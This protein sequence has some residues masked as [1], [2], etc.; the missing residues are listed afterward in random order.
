MPTRALFR[1]S[2]RQLARGF[3]LSSSWEMQKA[4]IHTPAADATLQKHH[5]LT[6]CVDTNPASLSIRHAHS[7]GD[8]QR[9]KTS[10]QESEKQHPPPL[11][12]P[13]PP[14]AHIPKP[15]PRKVWVRLHAA[16]V[17]APY[18]CQTHHACVCQACIRVY[19]LYGRGPPCH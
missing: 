11:P 19:C 8:C 4:T 15:D 10:G 2:I 18:V 12:Q 5:Q 1:Q 9:R 3:Q 14:R 6:A 16:P 17:S 7:T 13:V